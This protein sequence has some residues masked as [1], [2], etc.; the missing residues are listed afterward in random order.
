[1]N[2]GVYY[3]SPERL[4]EV[5]QIGKYTRTNKH[6]QMARSVGRLNLI[7]YNKTKKGK[8]Y[9]QM[10]G[11]K[12]AK[13]LRNK[14]IKQAKEQKVWNRFP[15]TKGSNNPRWLGGA[16]NYRGEDWKDYSDR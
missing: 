7:N 6:R 13:E 8:T 11:V 12:K 2:K 9:E 15:D 4:Q 16:D 10:Y 5:S 3:R 1:M 14:R